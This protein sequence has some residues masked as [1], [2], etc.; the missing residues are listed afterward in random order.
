MGLP[1][2]FWEKVKIEDA[3]YETACLV[4]TAYRLNNGYGRYSHNRKVAYAHRVAYE[5]VVGPIPDGL[6][7]DHLCRTR[8]CVNPSH[9]EPVTN[10]INILRGQTIMATNAGKTHCAQGHEF[11]PEN[12]IPV[13]EDG[14]KRACRT[15]TQAWR[16]KRNA[17]RRAERALA[18]A[19]PRTH[20]RRG[21][22]YDETNSYINRR[23]ARVC[24]TC[25]R[26]AGDR[27]RQRK[28]A[29]SP[30]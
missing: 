28:R 19:A 1:E 10:R 30:S 8:A 18:P 9:L 7:I 29:G 12:T 5:A 16:E 13:G 2:R 23:N 14:H 15:C 6:V 26:V 22:A 17:D 24:R 25:Q 27:S 4:W 11:T 21:H 3:G 20:C